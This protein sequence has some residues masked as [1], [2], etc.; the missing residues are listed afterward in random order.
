M[1]EKVTDKLVQELDAPSEGNRITYDI[2]VKGFGV[3]VTKAG[4][5]AFVFNYRVKGT[6]RERRY[7]IG[8]YPRW[9]V[10]A[11]RKEAE[12]LGRERDRG[13]D[14][15]GELH[16]ER[17]APT[18]ADLAERYVEE[19]LPKKRPSSR[20]DDRAMIDKIVLPRLGKLKVADVRHG[21]IDELHRSLSKRTPYRANRC[22]ALLSKMFALSIK[23]EMRGDNPARGIE[24][25]PEEKRTRYLSPEE[26]ARLTVALAEHP[27][28][29]SANVIRLLLLTGARRGEVL[30]ATWEQIDLE[31]GTWTKP[32]ALTKQRSEHRVPLSAAARRLLADMK[33]TADGPYLFPGKTP[34]EPLRDVKHFWAAVCRKAEIRGCRVHDLRHTYATILA[35]AGLSLPVIGALLGHTQAGTTQRYAHLFD[36]PLRRATE[37]VGAVVTAAENGKGGEVVPLRK[38][39][40]S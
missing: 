39:G 8:S 9:S 32:S 6:G 15:M 35:S 23:W 27:E 14:P 31:A 3:R 19:H 25:N 36:D 34:E 26:L 24:R 5:K 28:Q 12:R 22:V 18:V 21:D 17:V 10:A 29:T 30:S 37:R 20:R 2:D 7:T 38:D 4:A 16:E 40:R 13:G 33:A 1:A 11:A